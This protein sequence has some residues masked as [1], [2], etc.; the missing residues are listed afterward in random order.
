MG[1]SSWSHDFYAEREA[2][3]TRKGVDAFAYHSRTVSKPRAEQTVHPQM[4]P[5]GVTRES[6]DSDAHPNSVAI[7]VILDETGSMQ[8]TPRIMREALPKLMGLIMSK[9]VQ[10]PQILFGAVG[11]E[12]NRE[13]ASLQIGQFE[14]GVAIVDA[15]ALL[16]RE[17]W[18]LL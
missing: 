2:V 11:D 7:G 5:L 6:R 8:D 9:G 15:P 17:V 1:S 13:V 12:T 16:G 18:V 3:R 4:N 14:S 10:D